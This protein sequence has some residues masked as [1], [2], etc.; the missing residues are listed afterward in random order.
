MRAILSNSFRPWLRRRHLRR[1]LALR[2]A[3]KEAMDGPDPDAASRLAADLSLVPLPLPIWLFRLSGL[4]PSLDSGVE[5]ALRQTLLTQ[6]YP[7]I[8]PGLLLL[9]TDRPAALPIPAG[10]RAALRNRNLPLRCRAS[11]LACATMAVTGLARGIRQIIRTLLSASTG[12]L[13]KAPDAPYDVAVQ[14]PASFLRPGPRNADTVFVDWLLRDAPEGGL[15]LHS[16]TPAAAGPGRDLVA[17]PLPDFPGLRAR[18]AFGLAAARLTLG[19]M[20]GLVLARPEPALLLPET[21]LLAHAQAVGHESLARRYI[22][23]NSRWFLRP[24]FTRWATAAAGSSAVLA[25]YSTNTDECLR[26]RPSTRPPSFIPGYQSMDWDRY[27]V[28]DDDQADLLAAWGH[29]PSRAEVMG[30]IPLTDSETPLPALPGRSLAVF[31]V[32][33]FSPAR[34]AVMGLVPEYYRDAIAAQFLDDLRE[35][36]QSAGMT[37]ILKQKRERKQ[38]GPPRYEAA[39]RRLI[40]APHSVVL[41]PQISAARVTAACTATISMPFSSPS[42]IAAHHGRPAAF[43]DPTSRL[44]ASLRQTHGLPIIYGRT[45]LRQWLGD[46]SKTAITGERG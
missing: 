34:L 41:D 36:A 32:A 23:E 13:R 3:W 19:A 14:L 5:T 10:W 38:M 25:F 37:L 9:A 26:L 31:D 2:R 45:A 22:F 21:A 4:P 33:P 8:M 27:R 18:A 35:E 46:L 30:P 12:R 6:L 43:Y 24:L 42:L 40:D 20:A 15:W 11:S 44:I 7:Q 16:D 39:V 17:S 28:W 1:T 29:D